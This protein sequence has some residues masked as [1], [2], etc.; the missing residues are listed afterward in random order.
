MIP[1]NIRRPDDSWT[2][3]N[4]ETL[5][6]LMKT[7]FP[8]CR[9]FNPR[10]RIFQ[11]LDY[12]KSRRDVD[13]SKAEEMITNRKVAWTIQTLKPYKSAGL[14]E[15][16]PIMLQKS[17]SEIIDLLSKM[18]RGCLNLGYIPKQ[19]REVRVVFIPKAGKTSHTTPKDFRP[20]SLS[21]FLLKTLERLVNLWIKQTTDV[22]KQC[23]M[24]HA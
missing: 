18:Y 16:M 20:I 23:S 7:H 17:P 21:S 6:L 8:A 15:I 10:D 2:E 14:D 5:D 11:H 19:W 3:S 4:N 22:E 24:Q 9:D 13:K 12:S 1:S